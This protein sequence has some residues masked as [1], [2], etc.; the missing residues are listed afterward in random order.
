MTRIN[1]TAMA[2]ISKMWMKPPSVY[3]VTIPSSHKTSKTTKTVVS[4][5]TSESVQLAR[6]VR[7]SPARSSRPSNMAGF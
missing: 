3:D 4:T 2:T 5:V 1:T 6:R 7:K